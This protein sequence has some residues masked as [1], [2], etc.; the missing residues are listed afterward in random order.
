MEPLA[1]RELR[2]PTPKFRPRRSAMGK[3]K[4]NFEMGQFFGRKLR[5]NIE[6]KDTI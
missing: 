1:V 4:N 2:L 6:R 3:D 5:Q